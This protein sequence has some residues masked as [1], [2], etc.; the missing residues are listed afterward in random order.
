MQRAG[1]YPPFQ[2]KAACQKMELLILVNWGV[3]VYFLV[4]ALLNSNT[5]MRNGK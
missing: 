4:G 2:E 1:F 5:P 3:M